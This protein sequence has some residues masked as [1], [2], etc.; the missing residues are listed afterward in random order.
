MSR[1]GGQLAT[2]LRR[3]PDRPHL[4]YIDNAGVLRATAYDGHAW[5]PVT[6]PQPDGLPFGTEMH[7]PG[8][9]ATGQRQ[10]GHR[11]DVFAVDRDGL[12]RIYTADGVRGWETDLVPG[13]IGIPPGASLV[14]ALERASM[15]LDIFTVSRSGEPLLFQGGDDGRW[16]AAVLPSESVLPHGANLATG[17][18]EG[19]TLLSLFAI[20]RVG[21]LRCVVGMPE[22]GWIPES[23]GQDLAE[24]P[25]L[26]PGAPLATGYA[27]GTD[28]LSVFVVG[29]DGSLYEFQRGQFGWRARALPV[30]GLL[31]PAALTTA[32]RDGGRRLLLFV[33][34][35]EGR[36]RQYAHEPDGTWSVGVVPHGVGLPPGAPLA[37]GYR[38]GGGLLDLFV[39]ARFS[40]PPLYFTAQSGGWTG[41]YPI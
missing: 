34:D 16:R 13:G 3:D 39:L 33:V 14:T 11:L 19:R 17:Y 41:P 40:E 15:R 12:L 21:R 30:G 28:E 35:E 9:L 24:P 23:L 37:A 18:Q 7:P 26:P 36:L 5:S 6:L 22:R 27:G 20:D 10:R 32:Y 1:V 8:A 25:P 29:E 38:D 4:F 2:G 31:A